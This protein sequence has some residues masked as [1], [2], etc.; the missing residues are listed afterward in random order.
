M[1]R[2]LF[3]ARMPATSARF[4]CSAPKKTQKTQQPKIKPAKELPKSALGMHDAEPPRRFVNPETGE[5][6]GPAGPEP[7]RYGDWERKGRV[8]DF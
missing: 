5:Q 8:S 4:F 1:L 6:G 3:Y 7:T 2:S